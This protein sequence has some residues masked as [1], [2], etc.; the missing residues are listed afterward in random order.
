MPDMRARKS[1][2]YAAISLALAAS[3]FTSSAAFAAPSGDTSGTTTPAP[4]TR[5]APAPSAI[6]APVDPATAQF[7]AELAARQARLDAFNAQLDMLDQELAVAAEAY[8]GA[9]VQL[10]ATKE[11]LTVTKQDLSAAEAALEV[12]RTL[13]ET[14]IQA[15]YR[16]GSY[17]GAEL[18]LQSSSL[19]DF[20]TR[21]DFITTIGKSDADLATQLASQRDQIENQASDLQK[22]ELSAEA[23]E[24]DLKARQIEIQGRIAERQQLMAS[25]QTDLLTLLG[26][27]SARRQIDEAALL[28]E[29]LAGAAQVGVT[30]TPGSPVETAL[31]YH[32]IPYVWGGATPAGFDC[33]G[34]TMYV[35]AQHGVILPHHAADQYLMGTPVPANALMPGDLV[36]FGRSSIYHVGMYIGGGYFVQAPRT[37]DFVKVTKLSD[38]GDYAGARRYNWRPRTGPVLGV[39][40]ITLPG[41]LPAH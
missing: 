41:N 4:V 11:K 28:K 7:R 6:P 26:T 22:A 32:G 27:E 5:P 39:S 15:M 38:H 23:L 31:A 19:P 37:G 16:D 12:Q 30:V 3:L 18:L 1:A 36:F 21:L 29:I 14:R 34:L 24:F 40:S 9:T 2:A 10:A 17:S 8:N 13:L 35:Y 25:A 33:S 20:L